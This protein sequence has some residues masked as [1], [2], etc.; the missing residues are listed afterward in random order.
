MMHNEEEIVYIYRW[1]GTKADRVTETSQNLQ[2]EVDRFTQGI[3]IF[4]VL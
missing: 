3:T 4:S 2:K 1:K